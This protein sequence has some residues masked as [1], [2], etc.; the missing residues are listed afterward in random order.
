MSDTDADTFIKDLFLDL[1]DLPVDARER[2][3]LEQ[4]GD[5]AQL[6]AR[7]RELLEAHAEN[8]R[9]ETFSGAAAELGSGPI[10]LR[11]GNYT[12]RAVV[13][14]GGMGDVYDALHE[15]TGRRAAI[16]LIRAGIAT[17]HQRERFRIEAETLGRLNDPGIAQLYDAGL[18]EVVWPEGAQ[19]RRPFI[20]MEF[21]ENAMSC[22]HF[23]RTRKLTTRECVMLIEQVARAVQHAHQRGVI[24]RDLKPGNVLVGLDGRP[25]VVDFGIAR[26]LDATAADGI[27]ITGQIL[28]TVR[29]MSPEQA[30][31][32]PRHVDT[33]A[34]I[35]SLG[36][37]LYEM[38][39]GRPLIEAKSGSTLG[40][41]MQVLN[42][43]PPSLASLRQ[44]CAGDLDAI[45]HKAIERDAN[46]RYGSALGFANDLQ[47]Y[48]EGREVSARAPTTVERFVRVVKRNKGKFAA[49]ALIMLSLIGGIIGTTWG[50][51]RAE[52]ARR[53][54]ARQTIIAQ[55]K[56]VEAQEQ[57]AE[58]D[59]RREEAEAVN[60]FLNDDILRQAG[61]DNLPDKAIR[62]AIVQKL[63]DPAAAAVGTRFKDKPLIEAA[64]RASLAA[65]YHAIGKDDLA[66]PHA[67]A[68]LEIRRRMLGNDDPNTLAAISDMGILLQSQGKVAEAEPLMRE[69]LE[70][71]RRVRGD[72]DPGTLTAIN[73]IGY[74]LQWQGKLAEAEPFMREAL[75]RSRRVLGNDS[76]DTLVSINNM[77]YLLEQQGKFAEAEPLL[78]EM[79]ER[80]RRVLGDDHPTIANAIANLGGLYEMQGKLSDAEPLHREA[81]E[82]CRRQLGDDHPNTLRTINNL[83]LLLRN[84]G[85]LREAEPLM[86]E[87]LQRCRR[88]LGNDHPD[89]L[90]A[91]NNLGDLLRDQGKFDEA[92]PLVREMLEHCRT[93]PPDERELLNAIS[94]MGLLLLA[95]GKPTEAEPLLKDV[96]AKAK[97]SQDVG[98]TLLNIKTY[99]G[100]YARCLD[101]LNRHAEAAAMRKEFGVP[102]PAATRP[103]SLPTSQP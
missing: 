17:A 54:E 75:E 20:A 73:N 9:D 19:G 68:A 80:S 50:L 98:P 6:L 103:P 22:V 1:L 2:H 14:E 90:R 88:V 94:R 52:R 30:S 74:L 93:L 36:A 89:T 13:G 91:I 45:V 96:L 3:L 67:A 62:E 47:R 16:K 95:Q 7:I 28:G 46:D 84:E 18:A 5:D 51:V 44:E 11:V 92:E 21:V 4:C 32:D 100:N 77:G 29:Y 34:D 37:I 72:D 42:A 78:R 101:T 24:H 57:K 56:T 40:T 66:V 12:V 10:P 33:R 27:T 39:A 25:K 53:Q 48:L 76:E 23:A 61:P 38:L 58:A 87:G 81:L 97:A 43:T 35:Y 99:A 64:V 65:T 60:E 83:G 26:L 82:R 63:I 69:A 85:K 102:E 41:A 49:A 15:P 71:S 31:G 70:R 59:R 8:Q 86:R 79:L 55:E